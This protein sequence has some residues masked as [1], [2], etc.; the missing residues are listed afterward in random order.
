MA[1]EKKK[2]LGGRPKKEVYLNVKEFI[3]L[4]KFMQEQPIDRTVIKLRDEDVDI[5][6]TGVAYWGYALQEVL[7]CLKYIDK[8]CPLT[9]AKRVLFEDRIQK[10]TYENRETIYNYI[11]EN[12]L[13][14]NVENRTNAPKK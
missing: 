10:M 11:L 4:I 3:E 8:A 2:N 14:T 5:P 13:E 1:K 7:N 12:I 9:S 6:A